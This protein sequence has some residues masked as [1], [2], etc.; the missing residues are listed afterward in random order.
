VPQKTALISGISGQ[1]GSFLAELLLE[2]DYEVHGIIRRASTFNTDRID[3]IFG[4][5]RLHLHYGDVTDAGSLSN[6]INHLEPDEV[7]NLAAQ[8]HVKV[9]FLQPVY[10]GEVV[11][12]GTLKLLEAIRAYKE[13]TKKDIRF[14]QAS[15]SEMYG[16][17]SEPADESTPFNPRS[18]YAAAKLYAHNI[19]TN[20]R[21][22]YGMHINCG[23]LF[24]HESARRGETFVTRKITRAAGRI[25][26]GLQNKLYLGNLDA[27]RDWG[28][29]RDYVEAMWLMLQQDEPG[30]YVIATGEDHSVKEVVD[31]AFNY[32]DIDPTSHVD[33]A[34]RYLR[35]TEV[36]RLIGNPSKAKDKLGWKP[37]YGFKELIEDMTKHDLHLARVEAMQAEALK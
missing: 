30:D 26:H 20:Y 16:S 32:L 5:E 2:K 31:I 4:H 15:S 7:Y 27:R 36:E 37:K 9:S 13:R 29:S 1:D 3:H 11:G 24:N 21:E 10:T 12:I 35:P 19:A 25:K 34:E 8:S 23:I 28:H 22:G 6:L 18:P 17:L 14:Y 33:T